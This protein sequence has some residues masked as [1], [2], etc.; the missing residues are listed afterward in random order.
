MTA[1]HSLWSPKR[2]KSCPPAKAVNPKIEAARR[3]LE[4]LRVRRER[5]DARLRYLASKQA[6]RKDARRSI[7]VGAIMLA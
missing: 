4:Q 2:L 7:L 3:E 5:I 1:S 6:R